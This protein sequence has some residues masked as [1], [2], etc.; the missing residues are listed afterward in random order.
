MALS[1]LHAAASGMRALDE[2]LNVTANNLANINTVGFKRSRTNFEDLLYE[3]KREPGVP[4]LDDIPQP[5]GILVGLGTRVSGTQLDFST[6]SLVEGVKTDLAIE[7]EGFFQVRA[8]HNGEEVTAYTRAG[9]F[10]INR[11][12]ELVLG[13]SIGSPLEPP[14]TIPDEAPRDSL[15]VNE[16][17]RVFVRIGET[18]TEVGQI[19]LARFVNPEGLLSTGKNLFVATEA[20]GEPLEGDPG[21]DGLGILLQG[22]LEQSNADPIEELIS[23]IFTQRAFELNAQT[24][25]S[26]E[27]TLQI[28]ANLRR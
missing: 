12:G 28:V 23:L 13:N 1:A 5:H 8:L 11:D 4:N 19:T 2:K 21:E 6:D 16:R 24:I 20:S 22:F 15:R 7:G 3:V 18:D 10:V 17:G 27:Q 14:I 9:N 25:Q 26:A